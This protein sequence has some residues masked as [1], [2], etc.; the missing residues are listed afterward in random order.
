MFLAGFNHTS[1]DVAA[2]RE[3]LRDLVVLPH[4]IVIDIYSD[5]ANLGIAECSMS[6]ENS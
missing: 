3:I 6:F 2:F 5:I 4:N 1:G